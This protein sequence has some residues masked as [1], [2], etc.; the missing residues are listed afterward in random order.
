[1]NLLNSQR[2]KLG[3]NDFTLPSI[4]PQKMWL[5]ELNL[6]QGGQSGVTN[7]RSSGNLCSRE[8]YNENFA[9]MQFIH[10]VFKLCKGMCILTQPKMSTIALFS[11]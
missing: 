3:G 9:K 2:S 4:V 10:F 11:P 7:K 1:M 6:E 8:C 5:N